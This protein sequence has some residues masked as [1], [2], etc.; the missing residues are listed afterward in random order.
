M[1]YYIANKRYTETP[2]AA[3]CTPPRHHI[4]TS[5]MSRETLLNIGF[6]DHLYMQ[7]CTKEY[8]AL[9]GR[10]RT[11][12]KS[13][14]LSNTGHHIFEAELIEHK[15]IDLDTRDIPADSYLRYTEGH[16]IEYYLFEPSRD[17]HDQYLM[18]VN[19]VDRKNEHSDCKF[20]LNPYK[21]NIFSLFEK[22]VASES[23]SA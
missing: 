3:F 7:R 10:G 16:Y 4:T 23:P 15:K 19:I 11:P 18:V 20:Y 13:A 21:K 2:F 17:L 1:K 9:M 22:L 14:I 5:P 6:A 12:S 8:Q